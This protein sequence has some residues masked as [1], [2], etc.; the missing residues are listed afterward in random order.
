M[1]DTYVQVDAD[2]SGKKIYA[3]DDGS[4]VLKQGVILMPGAM[5]DGCSIYHKV[6]AASTNAA[7]VKAAPGQVYGWRIFNNTGYPVYVKLHNTAGAPTAGAGVVQTI[8][9]Q[10]GES[11]DDFIL[12]GLAFPTGIGIT[13]V[14]GIADNDATAVALNDCVVDLFYV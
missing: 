2:G 11:D 12:T 8:G 5:P 10:A 14:K 7:N 4:G 3:Q 13:I 9:V 6:S 1:S